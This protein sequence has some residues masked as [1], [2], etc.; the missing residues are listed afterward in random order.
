MIR[1]ALIE[2]MV[3]TPS[4]STKRCAIML[5]HDDAVKMKGASQRDISGIRRVRHS[6]RVLRM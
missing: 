4:A 1:L 3:G 2:I 6:R 5:F